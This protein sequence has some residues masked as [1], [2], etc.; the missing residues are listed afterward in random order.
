MAIRNRRGNL[1]DF[2]PNKMLAGEFGV[3][4]DTKGAYICFAPGDTKKM[5][6]YEDMSNDIKAV[7]ADVIAE[8]T[9]AINQ[10]ISDADTATA[11]ANDAIQTAIDA[12]VLAEASI[13]GANNAASNA[14]LKAGLADEA[15]IDAIDATATAN[16]LIALIEGETL[17]I[18]KPYKANYADILTAYPTPENGWVV[19]AADTSVEWRYNGISWVNIG[20]GTAVDT[21]TETTPGLVKGGGNVT[22]GEDGT[23][24][25]PDL[26]E[27]VDEVVS[28]L[29]DNVTQISYN[30]NLNKN[31]QH[32]K[33]IPI[34]TFISDDGDIADYNKLRPLSE[35]YGIP[36]VSAIIANRLTMNQTQ[37][38]YLQ[39]TLGWEIASHSWTHVGLSTLATEA[40]IETECSESKR[41]LTDLGYKVKNLVYPFGQND[42][43]VRRIAK[44]YY[45]CGVNVGDP[46]SRC[47]N[48]V[49]PALNIIR[50]P[51][52]SYFSTAIDGMP[53]TNSLEYYKSRVDEAVAKNGWIVFMVHPGSQEH[54]ATQQL[55][56][57]QTIQYIQ[58]LNVS[59]MTLDNALNICGNAFESSDFNGMGIFEAGDNINKP[60][61]YGISK[62]GALF[63][64]KDLKLIS[65]IGLSV[66]SLP[67]AFP[68]YCISVASFRNADS[69]GFPTG[70]GTLMTYRLEADGGFTFQVWYDYSTDY[71]YKRRY[72]GSTWLQWVKLPLSSDIYSWFGIVVMKTT[73]SLLGTA[74][75]TNYI[76]FEKVFS[77]DGTQPTLSK[78]LWAASEISTVSTSPTTIGVAAGVNLQIYKDANGFIYIKYAVNGNSYPTLYKVLYC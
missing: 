60:I 59:I 68:Q 42:E 49:V 10:S 74:K 2:D 67:T 29:A 25:A 45:N 26:Q 73:F 18:Y 23:L 9:A 16:S 70:A 22:I 36:F 50:I 19:V 28:Q 54:D 72:S 57:E 4:M 41:I 13:L 27:E 56:L 1:L 39:D 24:N 65:N 7:T 51:L 8:T 52:G 3:S 11:S 12:N 66:N 62:D 21:A 35:T 71:T 58:S 76:D 44:K 5:S 34:V 48:L 75:C 33:R 78:T 31:I 69:G 15:T 53:A 32:S 61:G 47:M 63:N 55:Y 20:I 43:R 46:I 64:F 30:A 40:L 77:T 17:R 37:L 14:D 6:T 38:L